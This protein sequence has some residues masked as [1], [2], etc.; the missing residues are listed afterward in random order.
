MVRWRPGPGLCIPPQLLWLLMHVPAEAS[1][2]APPWLGL[3]YQDHLEDPW[4]HSVWHLQSYKGLHGSC[5]SLWLGRGP[6]TSMLWTWLGGQVLSQ[7]P[8]RAW[9][10][11]LPALTPELLQSFPWFP[12]E[13][14]RKSKGALCR[15][16]SG[17]DS[18][19]SRTHTGCA[20]TVAHRPGGSNNVPSLGN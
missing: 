2:E 10:M 1:S 12:Q 17:R 5:S 8:L 15:S 7:H 19:G 16:T 3:Q 9:R 18:Q 4:T 13:N 6:F 20:S 14:Q 11:P